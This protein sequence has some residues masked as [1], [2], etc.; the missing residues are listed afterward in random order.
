MM[1][2]SGGMRAWTFPVGTETEYSFQRVSAHAL[3]GK[4]LC[5][6]LTDEQLILE[7][8]NL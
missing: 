7:S 3:P 6:P 1:P 2:P 5:Q 8:M 4:V